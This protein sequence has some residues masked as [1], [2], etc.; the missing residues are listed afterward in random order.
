LKKR[1]GIS[2]PTGQAENPKGLLS[3]SP[4]RRI[5]FKKITP[6]TKAH[7]KTSRERDK[8]H[9]KKSFDRI[10]GS[11]GLSFYPANPVHPV[12]KFSEFFLCLGV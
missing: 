8:E 2:H 3:R 10:T 6:K 12:R 11:T 1:R 9:A 7:A 4:S 5:R